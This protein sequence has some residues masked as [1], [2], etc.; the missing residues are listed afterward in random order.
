MYKETK[1]EHPLLPT[2]ENTCIKYF[3]T[4]KSKSKSK[5]KRNK[6]KSQSQFHIEKRPKK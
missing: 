3:I 2:V 6:S 5:Q 1:R 4:A